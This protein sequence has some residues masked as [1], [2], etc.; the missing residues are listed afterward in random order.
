MAV[1]RNE[2]RQPHTTDF[3]FEILNEIGL[4]LHANEFVNNNDLLTKHDLAEMAK[5]D[6]ILVATSLNESDNEAL[7]D[8]LDTI[9]GWSGIVPGPQVHQNMVFAANWAAERGGMICTS[10]IDYEKWHEIWQRLCEQRGGISQLT[11]TK[12]DEDTKLW[13]WLNEK[14]Y[15]KYKKEINIGGNSGSRSWFLAVLYFLLC[16]DQFMSVLQAR[17][18][19]TFGNRLLFKMLQSLKIGITT[20]NVNALQMT[21]QFVEAFLQGH[22]CYWGYFGGLSTGFDIIRRMAPELVNQFSVKYEIWSQCTTHLA[23]QRR[24]VTAPRLFLKDRIDWD[25]RSGNVI[26]HTQKTRQCW[27][28]RVG[29]LCQTK[30]T[31]RFIQVSS[32]IGQSFMIYFEHGIPATLWGR[33]MS[34][35]NIFFG[36]EQRQIGGAIFKINHS[37][38]VAA[39]LMMNPSETASKIRIWYKMDTIERKITKFAK[40][41]RE[42]CRIIFVH[43]P[44]RSCFC[45]NY[46]TSRMIQCPRCKHWIH[47][48]CAGVT[49]SN[50]DWDGSDCGICAPMN[51]DSNL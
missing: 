25:E 9:T 32:P 29:N 49:S 8:E 21:T 27:S 14:V 41:K 43:P 42:D 5:E 19:D 26:C 1:D 50:Q 4:N 31:D 23:I 7:V 34:G 51:V 16:E 36:E 3:V 22:F 17:R 35:L 46:D 39:Y 45:Q 18:G 37:H 15:A 6:Q 20:Q 11:V 40:A 28:S 38:F 48:D 13:S 44:E 33:I 12:E 10:N 30:T 24:N 47:D 2:E